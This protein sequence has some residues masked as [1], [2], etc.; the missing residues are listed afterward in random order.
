M[1]RKPKLNEVLDLQTGLFE[2]IVQPIWADRY[3]SFDM[4]Y[5]FLANHAEKVI[6][7]YTEMSLDSTTQR[8]TSSGS[9][10]L[11]NM[12][13]RKY[14]EQWERKY[15]VLNAQYVIVDNYNLRESEDVDRTHLENIVNEMRREGTATTKVLNELTKLITDTRN[16]TQDTTGNVNSQ[17]TTEDN[18]RKTDSQEG[19]NI[20]TETGDNTLSFEGRKDTETRNL[21][22]AKT[23][24]LKD[25]DKSTN[26]LDF[27]DRKDATTNTQNNTGTVGTEQDQTV[28]DTTTDTTTTTK[29]QFG[30]ET[31]GIN[32]VP[33][34][35]DDGKLIRGGNIET[36]GTGKTTNNLTS[37][38]NGSTTKT[39]KEQTTI[40]STLDK[41]GTDTTINTGSVESGKTG[42]ERNAV[43]L[44]TTLEAGIT[45]TTKNEGT[46]T[47]D[48]NSDNT[49]KVVDSIDGTSNI[50]D[51]G[52]VDTTQ[53]NSETDNGNT[54]TTG[55]SNEKRILTR[56]G[57]IGVTT[58]TQ[59]LQE[60]IDFWEYSFLEDIY[61]DVEKMLCL[62]V[63]GQV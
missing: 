50:T 20:T 32:G 35:K 31:A 6:S 9:S 22:D 1:T 41:T 62:H 19:R 49:I 13:Y 36:T 39:G 63:Y 16:S 4:D 7:R 28:I 43:N 12:I 54:E 21:T 8:L 34:E 51:N 46:V 37:T 42:S 61:K 2:H 60:H 18:L 17:E 15:E 48:V 55:N 59:L 38:D 53:N 26:V 25:T 3:E 33:V 10:K 30:F 52:S 45:N 57:N 24:A 5:E 40:E 29:N 58:T 27:V 11:I 23:L 14:K 44:T 47:T 56:T